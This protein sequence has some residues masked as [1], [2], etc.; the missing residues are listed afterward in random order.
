MWNKQYRNFVEKNGLAGVE[1]E[2]PE[3]GDLSGIGA[4]IGLYDEESATAEAEGFYPG[5]V[6]KSDGY[7]PIGEDLLGGGDP[8][9]I[10]IREAQPCAIYRIYH[11]SV[12][13]SDY[14]PEQAI[15]KVLNSYEELL[16]YMN[17]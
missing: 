17:T 16:A 4:S 15:E 7:V 8:Y 11:D 9:F 3:E 10:N 6:V 5:M 12:L 13:D 14:D 1:V 2:I